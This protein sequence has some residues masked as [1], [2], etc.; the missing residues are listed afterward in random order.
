LP[1][2]AVNAAFTE[3]AVT[4]CT[5][6]FNSEAVELV[7]PAPDID[8]VDQSLPDGWRPKSFV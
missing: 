4:A 3:L 2:S 5:P 6:L 7:V 8:M 1:E